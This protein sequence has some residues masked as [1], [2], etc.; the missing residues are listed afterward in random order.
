VK[1]MLRH[2]RRKVSNLYLQE[3][4]EPS[5][6]D[7]QIAWIPHEPTARCV[8]WLFNE[9]QRKINEAPPGTMT[10]SVLSKIE[11]EIHKLVW[12]AKARASDYWWP[13]TL[14]NAAL[15]HEP[16]QLRNPEMPRG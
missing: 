9:G 12:D 16:E 14:I 11:M 13:A 6:D 3:G 1:G 7:P 4:T 5:D 10:Y 15:P 8:V 2:G